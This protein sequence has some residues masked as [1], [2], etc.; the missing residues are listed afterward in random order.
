V[1]AG[2]Y[3]NGNEFY[4]FSSCRNYTE[5]D[6]NSN[7]N[8]SLFTKCAQCFNVTYRVKPYSSSDKN[9]NLTDYD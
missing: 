9:D 1:P 7:N 3:Q 8:N 2:Q 5:N 6:D 4:Y